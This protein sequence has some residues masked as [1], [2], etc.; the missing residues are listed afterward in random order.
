MG[1]GDARRWRWLFL[2]CPVP[3]RAVCWPHAGSALRRP[4]RGRP[5]RAVG[6]L[7]VR[8]RAA[9]HQ[10]SRRA[11]RPASSGFRWPGAGLRRGRPHHNAA[12]W[13]VEL[14][15][16]GWEV[17]TQLSPVSPDHLMTSARVIKG[18]CSTK[19]LAMPCA[20]GFLVLGTLT[21]RTGLKFASI[22]MN[23]LLQVSRRWLPK[24]SSEPEYVNHILFKK[25]VEGVFGRCCPR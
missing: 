9:W 12:V 17:T 3:A 1:S 2:K 19:A 16:W 5:A 24:S 15:P 18:W 23:K 10:Y 7:S 20:T 4:P 14:F 6:P 8:H 11:R 22:T 21:C 25:T 13:S